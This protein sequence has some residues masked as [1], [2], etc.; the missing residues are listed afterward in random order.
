MEIS[1]EL[2]RTELQNFAES[3]IREELR[4]LK[5]NLLTEL[6][7][8]LPKP[9]S[10]ASEV[11]EAPPRAPAILQ[12]VAKHGAPNNRK[13]QSLR[14]MSLYAGPRGGY[15]DIPAANYAISEDGDQDQ[16]SSH[17]YHEHR[18]T[19]AYTIVAEKKTKTR[20]GPERH[21]SGG[22]LLEVE[23]VSREDSRGVGR[24]G[25]VRLQALCQ[26]FVESA[27]FE[28]ASVAA[29]LLNIGW[30]GLHTDWV[31]RN[32]SN[33]TPWEFTIVD[34]IFAV[35]TVGELAVRIIANGQDFFVDSN[36]RWNWFD[37]T[38]GITQVLDVMITSMG[39]GSNAAVK[40]FRVIKMI[41]IVRVARIAVAFPE[42]NILMS[43]I[44]ESMS[45]LFWV[46]LLI[47][48]F[49][50]T[51]AILITQLVSEHK[52]K[53]GR[54][55]MHG[56]EGLLIVYFDTLDTTII[57]L[58]KVIS[59]GIDWGDL[60][61]PLEQQI[62]PAF[63]Y[64][65]VFFVGFQ[66][67]AMLNVITANFVDN[68]NKRAVKAEAEG[69]V[70]ALWD[71]LGHTPAE[72]GDDPFI[73]D[74]EDFT[75]FYDHPTMLKFREAI[76]AEDLGVEDLF[77]L[78]DSNG[79]GI[80]TA[81]NFLQVSVTL[82]GPAQA[83]AIAKIGLQISSLRDFVTTQLQEQQNLFE[84]RHAESMERWPFRSQAGDKFKANRN[85]HMNMSREVT[86]P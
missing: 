6:R 57:S 66:V 84:T 78:F 74:L 1:Q 8:V 54:P 67:F 37:L 50:Y 53:L 86:E 79:D 72:E 38:V 14:R 49:L 62:S 59:G 52:M 61:A 13:T 70:A 17:E 71:M 77:K 76:H 82:I 11:A 64:F 4:T 19:S 24:R 15:S 73:I 65:F 43:S 83:T 85:V 41:R 60:V 2:L 40:N 69:Q 29:V 27:S 20:F 22:K 46:L 30:I 5:E 9:C 26:E 51:V 34:Y 21:P 23:L 80:V 7:A 28:Y 12:P 58:F 47:F 3:T 75:K 10:E 39:N 16:H 18:A 68:A 32:W 45:S 33:D 25:L 55:Q 31:G 56:S 63:K 36:W 81:F 42:L 35:V 48:V 44:M